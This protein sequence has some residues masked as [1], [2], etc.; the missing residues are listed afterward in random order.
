MPTF[1]YEAMN[2]VGQPTKGEVVANS[3]EDAIAKVRGMG[4]FPTK[5][6]EKSVFSAKFSREPIALKSPIFAR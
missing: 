2:S 6:K 3:A 5:I 4:H 1:T